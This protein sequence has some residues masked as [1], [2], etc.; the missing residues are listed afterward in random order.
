MPSVGVPVRIPE[1]LI[2][3]ADQLLPMASSWPAFQIARPTRAAML[4]LA[5]IRGLDSLEQEAG[6]GPRVVR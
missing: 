4:R 3:R 1:D 2:V 5:L 6:Q